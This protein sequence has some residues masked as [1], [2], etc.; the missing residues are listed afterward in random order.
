MSRESTEEKLHLSQDLIYY[1]SLLGTIAATLFFFG[2]KLSRDISRAAEDT[3]EL[4]EEEMEEI[5]TYTA[6]A[7][8]RGAL[9]DYEDL[10]DV[11]TSLKEEL[12]QVDNEIKEMRAILKKYYR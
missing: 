6:V 3:N 8:T 12:K 4:S 9:R 11:L 1:E 2:V 5:V 7:S 10:N